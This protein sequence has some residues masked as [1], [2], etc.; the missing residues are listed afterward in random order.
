MRYNKH[1]W[2]LLG[3]VFLLLGCAERITVEDKFDGGSSIN[4][5][6]E[7][8]EL[9]QTLIDGGQMLFVIPEPGIA[10]YATAEGVVGGNFVA[11]VETIQL[12]GST[13]S[14]YGL[15]FR[16]QDPG[17]FYRFNITGNGYYLVEK[18]T[19]DGGW[20]RLTND[21]QET[22]LLLTGHNN[23]NLIKVEARGT[24]LGF[25]INGFEVFSINDPAF[26]SGAIAL[27]AGTFDQGGLIVAF[28]N[29]VLETR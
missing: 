14:G 25:S 1:I 24:N 17:Q 7:S 18:R 2:W 29:F 22:T 6:L 21:W 10:R 8:D 20:E 11:E 13:N 16:M 28:D 27:N 26:S 19:A 15:L 3:C 4:W 5:L 12:D 23:R 9:G